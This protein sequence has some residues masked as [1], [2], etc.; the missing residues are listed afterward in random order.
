MTAVG[1]ATVPAEAEPTREPAGA[2]R[3]PVW[4]R[5]RHGWIAAG[6]YLAFILFLD[7]HAV[8]HLNS[9]CGC[10]RTADPTQWMWSWVWIPYAI[11]HGLNPLVTH[12][13]WYPGPFDL[14]AVTLSPAAAIPGIP[15]DALFGPVAAFNLLFFAAPVVSGW[16]AYRLCRYLS[17]APWASIFAG[18]TYGFSAYELA[19]ELAHMNLVW[20][21]VPPLIVLVLA[22]LIRAEVSARRALLQITG[23]LIIEF[24]LSTE[25]FFTMALFIAAGFVIGWLMA[26]RELRR[27]IAGAAAV[28]FGAGVLTAVVWSYYIYESFQAPPASK[29]FPPFFPADLV[30]YFLPTDM[31]RLGSATFA[32][33][34]NRIYTSDPTEQN[35]YLGIPLIVMFVA[36]GVSTWR[37]R[38]TR[39]VVL[40]TFVAFVLSLG[41]TLTIVGNQ[42]FSLPYHWIENLP[43]FNLL[44]PS[45]LSLYVSLGVAVGAAIW[46][47]AAHGR[48]SRVRRW[49]LALASLVFLYPNNAFVTPAFLSRESDFTQP[50]FF[51][52]SLYRHYIRRG[53]V[54]LPL[55]FSYGPGGLSLL[56]QADTGMYFKLAS[57]YFGTV[58]PPSYAVNPL[59]LDLV[60]Q[61]VPPH[62]ARDLNQLTRT[63]HVSVI[64]VQDGTETQYLPMIRRAGWRLRADVGGIRVY[65]RAAGGAH[66]SR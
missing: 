5:D 1:V 4:F 48:R 42:T 7:R 13:F 9:V 44:T 56:W 31:F 54:V 27:R 22:R 32:A 65:R 3:F 17:G 57:G 53:E 61:T 8:A 34:T 50:R 39:T 66:P 16:A 36:Y 25:L 15:L 21:F 35:S 63:H 23:L 52:T 33:V 11:T 64:L 10:A 18:Y 40:T 24:G 51:T 28:T 62:A 60:I 59:S 43:L 20:V 46:L 55:P 12:L 45:R 6:L 47:A 2:G 41:V 29:G 14:A 19:H 38:I 49:F 26:P 58:A 37:R 30:S